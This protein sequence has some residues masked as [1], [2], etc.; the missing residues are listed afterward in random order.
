ML[1]EALT[2]IPRR[3]LIATTLTWAFVFIAFF[4]GD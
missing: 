2:F 3:Y 1:I 4:L